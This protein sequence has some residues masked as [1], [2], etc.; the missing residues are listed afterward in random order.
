[1]ATRRDSRDLWQIYGT[2][3]TRQEGTQPYKDEGGRTPAGPR[4]RQRSSPAPEDKGEAEARG[5]GA[6]RLGV[7]RAEVRSQHLPGLRSRNGSGARGRGRPAREDVLPQTPARRSV[8]V[9]RKREF[10]RTEVNFS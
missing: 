3:V 5:G 1:M 8:S 4:S 7:G 9:Y 10:L 6:A 2:L